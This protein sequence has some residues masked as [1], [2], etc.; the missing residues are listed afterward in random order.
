MSL[1]LRLI[2]V[3]IRSQ[4]QYRLSFLIDVFSTAGLIVIEFVSFAAVLSRFGSLGGWT[5]GEVA[6]LYGMVEISFATMD[7][8]FSGFDPASFSQQIRRGVFDQFLLRPAGL[9]LQVF[10]SEFMLRRLGRLAQGALVL[11]LGLYLNP[12]A[13]TP[14]KLLYLPIVYVSTTAFFGGLFV[15]GATTCF[16]TVEALE[17]INI[18]TYGGSAMLSYPMHIYGEWIRRF[19][20]FVIPGALLIYY[21]ALYFLDK[22]DPFGWPPLLSFLAPLAGFGVLALA[23]AFWR[24]G[25]RHYTSTGV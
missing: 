10:G 1:Y 25:L 18:F 4:M 19:F 24:L 14:G 5:L 12:V 17:A 20:T 6:F 9:A 15:V 13:W 2:S 16:W 21:P 11:G 22:P 23:F 3:T 8:L 7:M